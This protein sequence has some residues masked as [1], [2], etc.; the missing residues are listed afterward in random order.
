MEGKNIVAVS[1]KDHKNLYEKNEL[2]VLKDYTI[3][4]IRGEGQKAPEEGEFEDIVVTDCNDG[5]CIRSAIKDHLDTEDIGNHLL[6]FYGKTCH[7]S[8]LPPLTDTRS[9]SVQKIT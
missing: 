6:V 8:M 7:R 9:C 2:R 1:V 5:Q 4:L 3:F